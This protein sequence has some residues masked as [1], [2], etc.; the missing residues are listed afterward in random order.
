MM[1]LAPLAVLG[2]PMA[3][4]L[5]LRFIFSTIWLNSLSLPLAATFIETH[6]TQ[7]KASLISMTAMSSKVRLALSRALSMAKPGPS[8]IRLALMAIEVE[9]THTPTTL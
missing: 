2:W 1:I 7:A 8:G 5:P 6:G 3:M 4:A 9:A